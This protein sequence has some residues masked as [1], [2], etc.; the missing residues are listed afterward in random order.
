L[1]AQTFES[2][3]SQEE[4]ERL[5]SHLRRLS[6]LNPFL[7]VSYLA[8]DWAVILG[9]ILFSQGSFHL[10]SYFLAVFL[11]ATRQN[12]LLVIAHDGSHF[13]LVKN[14]RLNTWLTNLFCAY[15]LFFQMEIY[16]HHHIL[17]H[18]NTN[19]ELDPDI[20]Y[21]KGL[22]DF[23]FPMRLKKFLGIFLLEFT[24][25]I[26]LANLRRTLKYNANKEVTRTLRRELKNAKLGRW[27]FY[28][29]LA[30]ALTI[31]GGWKI[32]LLYWVVPMAWVFPLLVRLK[33]I[34]EHS[35]LRSDFDLQASRD[36]TCSWLEGWIIAPHYIRLHLTH[37]LYPSVP[38]YHL[39]E[40]HRVLCGFPAYREH[41]HRNSTYVLPA[42]DAVWRELTQA[43][44]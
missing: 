25:F 4:K 33:N 21:R 23:E 34:S 44:S 27:I 38:F 1:A 31:F 19:T 16:R 9:V 17:H 29:G 2:L 10:W 11:I 3:L 8:L 43:S 30:A 41:A 37:H 24:G 42:R 40:M 22:S 14:R 26:T 18:Q 12:A 5:R 6:A 32:F 35:C 13:R 7:G 28:A 39:P 15:P 36:V 20:R